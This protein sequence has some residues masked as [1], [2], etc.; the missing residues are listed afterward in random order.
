MPFFQPQRTQTSIR[1]RLGDRGELY[2]GDLLFGNNETSIRPRLG[3]RGERPQLNNSGLR[4]RILQFGHV[5]ATVEKENHRSIPKK[6]VTRLQ[7][8]HVWATVEND[9]QTALDTAV[10][11]TLQFGHVW[12]TVENFSCSATP[13]ARR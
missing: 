1:P 2:N 4:I 5:W 12:A 11:A 10:Q 9:A 6:R 13:A 3:D 8:G 7:F